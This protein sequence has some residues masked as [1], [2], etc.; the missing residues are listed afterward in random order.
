MLNADDPE[1]IISQQQLK[2]IVTAETRP[3]VLWIGAG[4]SKWLGYPSWK[5]LTLQLRREFAS[6]TAGFNNDR[7]LEL[8]N[9]REFPR[10]F[11]LCKDLDSARYYRFIAEAFLPRVQT[12]AYKKFVNFLAEINPLYVLTTN[13]DEVLEHSLPMSVVLQRSDFERSIDL[14]HKRTPFVA[15]LHGSIS[16]VQNTVF[17]SVDY[18]SLVKCTPYLQILKYIFTACTVVSLAASS[19]SKSRNAA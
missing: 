2:K 19:L 5:E 4:S 16:S 6:S 1:S 10:V 18:E 9:K 8:I 11:Q 12:Q 15:K 3:L 14:I 13:V 7:A 17:T